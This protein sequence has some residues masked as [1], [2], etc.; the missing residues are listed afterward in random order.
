MKKTLI[1]LCSAIFILLAVAFS[2]CGTP[3]PHEIEWF[4]SD[5]YLSEEFY[6]HTVGFDQYDHFGSVFSNCAQIS[7]KGDGSFYFKDK[8]GKEYEGTYK[9]KRSGYDTEVT[10]TFP[11]GS[12]AEGYYW[13][14]GNDGIKYSARFEISGINYYFDDKER[15][16][17]A[18]SLNRCLK[19]LTGAICTFAADGRM[20][21]EHYPYYENLKRGVIGKVGEKFVAVAGNTVILLDNTEYWCYSVNG[22][23]IEKGRL[24]E[25]GCV[26][27]AGNGRIAIYYVEID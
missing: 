21:I 9:S 27:R 11:D 4:L 15:S 20:E 13:D 12:K 5:Y 2:G 24:K 8:D 23:G 19:N 6:Y 18:D 14:Y 22:E 17:D 3:S 16:F 26:I 1:S 10:L 7:F 25:G